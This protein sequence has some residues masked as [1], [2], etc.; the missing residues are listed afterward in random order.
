M[1]LKRL[2]L[3]LIHV[4]VAI[5]LVPINST[6]NR[7]MIKELAIS[8]TLVAILASL[9]YLLAPIQV[10]IG[11]YSDRHP[12]LGYRRTPYILA[13]LIL[14]VLGLIVSPYVAFLMAE[15]FP[16]GLLAGCPG[17]RCLGDGLQP[18]RRFLPFP[19]IR[20]FR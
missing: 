15:N 1:L 10:A 13:G 2:Q 3:G 18:L 20:A 7:V 5:T 6:L 4:A 19:G 8:A 9:P 12:I 11:S 17:I 14:C 16:L